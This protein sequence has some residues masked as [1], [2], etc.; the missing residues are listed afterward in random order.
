MH[1]GKAQV[2]WSGNITEPVY[3]IGSSQYVFDGNYKI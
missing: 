3:L 1:G 2:K